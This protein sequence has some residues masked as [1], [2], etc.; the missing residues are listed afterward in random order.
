MTKSFNIGWLTLALTLAVAASSMAMRERMPLPGL[1]NSVQGHVTLG[2]H[3]VSVTPGS[4]PNR[5]LRT[6]EV[7]ATQHGNAEVLLTPGAF[8]R[9]GHHS[10]A[11]MVSQSLEDSQV[12]LIRGKALLRA[13]SVFK[14]TLSVVMDGAITRID[15]KGLYGFNARR[16]TI[17]VLQGKATIYKGGSRFIVK[18]GHELALSKGQPL[19]NQKLSKQAFES[20]QLFRWSRLRDRYE[21][22]ARQSVQQAIA[23]SGRWQGRGWYWSPFWGFYTYL[24]SEGMYFS[25]YYYPYGWDN[26]G[27]GGWG[28]WDDDDD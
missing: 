7:L 26:W 27:W 16:E 13:D 5:V 9:L 1:L 14:H 10:A 15:Q 22:R 11:R 24:P 20:G 6:H 2:A 4:T 3:S 12:R 25:P 8:L 21:S 18:K 17:G 19:Y 28:G 23:Q